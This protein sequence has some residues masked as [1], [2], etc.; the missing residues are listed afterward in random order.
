MKTTLATIGGVVVA[1]WALVAFYALRRWWAEARVEQ[2]K[3]AA[4]E[5]APRPPRLVV[6]RTTRPIA[7]DEQDAPGC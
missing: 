7:A 2:D 4:R 5:Q 3:R 1:C 6:V